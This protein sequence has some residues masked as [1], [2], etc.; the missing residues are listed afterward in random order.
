MPMTRRKRFYSSNA[1][2][3]EFLWVKDGWR[4]KTFDETSFL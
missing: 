3:N 2:V 1:G 4:L